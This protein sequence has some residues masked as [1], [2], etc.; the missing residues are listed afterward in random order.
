[1]NYLGSDGIN[2]ETTLNSRWFV[3]P[4]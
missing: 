4:T 1:M 2:H 3:R